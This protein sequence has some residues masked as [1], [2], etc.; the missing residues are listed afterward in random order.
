MLS[1]RHRQFGDSKCTIWLHGAWLVNDLILIPNSWMIILVHPF[2]WSKI[3]S[4]SFFLVEILVLVR[5]KLSWQHHSSRYRYFD[6]WLRSL[7]N[8]TP[9]N[10]SR[11]SELTCPLYLNF[12]DFYFHIHFYRGVLIRISRIRLPSGD[13]VNCRNCI[14][15]IIMNFRVTFWLNSVFPL[16]I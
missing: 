6:L 8:N 12:I 3:L 10:Y 14:D 5:R 7:M 2:R 1:C 11:A 9:F 13:F 16:G 15:K 4:I